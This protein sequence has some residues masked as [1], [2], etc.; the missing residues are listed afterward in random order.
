MFR[1]P[2]ER[3]S[4]PSSSAL[5]WCSRK[6]KLGYGLFWYSGQNNIDME[7]AVCYIKCVPFDILSHGRYLYVR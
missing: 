2:A 7:T 3:Q 5:N 4:N 6:G 1:L